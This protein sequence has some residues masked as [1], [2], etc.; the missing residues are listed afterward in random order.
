MTPKIPSEKH[1]DHYNKAVIQSV[2]A[3]NIVKIA[4]CHL[5]AQKNVCLSL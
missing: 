4:L 5:L 3:I 1:R 2:I